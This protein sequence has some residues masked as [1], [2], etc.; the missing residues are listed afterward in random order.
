MIDEIHVKNVALI[1][2]VTLSPSKGLTVL[3]GETGAGKTALLSACKLLCGERADS[4]SVR[5]GSDVLEVEGRFFMKEEDLEHV[6][7]RKVGV[8][9]RSRISIDGGMASVGEL[10]SIIGPS[11]DLCGQ[12]EHQHLMKPVNQAALLDSWSLDRIGPVKEEYSAAFAQA[13]KA[14]LD[15]QRIQEAG[16][17]S[18]AKL[19]EARFI[20][21]QI[22]AV[23]PHQG[24]YENLLEKATRSEHAETLRLV[25][26]STHD[27]LSGD[28]GVIDALARSAASMDALSGVDSRLQEYSSVLRETTFTLEDLSREVRRYRDSVEFDPEAA[29]FDQDRL[30]AMQSL[31]RSWGPH[32]EDVLNRY[33]QAQEMISLT[34]CSAER[35]QAA[36]TVLDEAEKRLVAAADDFDEVREDVAPSFLTAVNE[37]MSCLH[38][39]TAALVY[40]SE[41]FARNAWTKKSPSCPEYL[42]RP[43]EGMS[44]RPLARIASGG[45]LSRVMLA[46]KVVLGE[47]DEVE[48]LIFD[49]VDAGVGGRAAV[50]L[51]DVL[52]DLAK[53]HQVIVVTHL[54]QV[55]VVAD[56]HYKVARIEKSEDGLPETELVKLSDDE[57]ADEVARMLS[58]EVTQ[59]S[60]KH[61]KEML[62]NAQIR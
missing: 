18:S 46:I 56:T 35:E 4:S 45:E 38:M 42:F 12:H 41:R 24:E 47:V 57:R 36:R 48:T 29:A 34:D 32:M 37:Q 26:D 14:A 51:A 49:E 60:V 54:A 50:A 9:G 6:V 3:T 33:A 5:E 10:Q 19:D 17:V 20:V 1:R 52:L 28:N 53:T 62:D 40:H 22:E 31:M 15:L 43:A 13:E 39:P 11:V 59:A 44:A 2:E 27:V 8:D 55:A 61:A 23:G 25:S 30:A 16:Q 58:G 7:V 21:K